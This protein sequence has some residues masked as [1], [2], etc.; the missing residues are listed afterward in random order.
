ML[1]TSKPEDQAPS[2]N[3]EIDETVDES[4]L[5]PFARSDYVEK[6]PLAL[7]NAPARFD[8]RRYRK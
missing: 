8:G 3:P 5:P 2:V 7:I 6:L 4:D 1:K